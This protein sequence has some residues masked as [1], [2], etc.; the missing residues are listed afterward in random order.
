MVE[1]IEHFPLMIPGAPGSDGI[2][3]LRAPYDRQLLAT[4]DS[5]GADAIDLALSTAYDCYRS[6]DRW[7]PVVERIGILQRLKDKIRGQKE[8]LAREAAEE[9]GKPLIDS[10]VEVARAIDGVQICI[11]TLRTEAGIMIPMG[12]NAA[13]ANRIAYSVREPIGVVV[14]VSAFNHPVNLIVHQVVPAV[15]SGCPV[16]IKPAEDTP[17]SCMRL[18]RMLY[19]AGL[20]EPWCQALVTRDLSVAEKLV[21]DPRVGFFSFIGSARV[22]WMLRNKLAPGARCALEH[23]GVAPVI[24]PH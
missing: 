11:D 20:P 23:G 19:E 18:V 10:R 22:G 9:G 13:S 6:R 12:V 24:A 3:E 2:V 21:S 4:L 14:A 5:A 7:L 17:R 8:V 16:I 15:A 1:S